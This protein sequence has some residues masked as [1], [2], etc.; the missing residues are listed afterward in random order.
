MIEQR[1]G[2][3]DVIRVAVRAEAGAVALTCRQVVSDAAKALA[4]EGHRHYEGQSVVAQAGDE[5]QV[6]TV[7]PDV[8]RAAIAAGIADAATGFAGEPGQ[9]GG[10]GNRFGLIHALSL[11]CSPRRETL[12]RRCSHLPSRAS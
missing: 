2:V 9:G 8:I 4:Q 3:G 10:W 11:A 1:E 7:A 6:R 5:E 12:S